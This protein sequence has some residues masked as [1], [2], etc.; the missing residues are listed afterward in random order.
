[1]QTPARSEIQSSSSGMRPREF[2]KKYDVAESLVYKGCRDGSIPCI[3]LGRRF[4]I[5]WREWEKKANA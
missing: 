3:R 4:V 5:L 1:M 2:A